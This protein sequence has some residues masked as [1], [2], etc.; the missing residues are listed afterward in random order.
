MVK[1]TVFFYLFI[2]T[3]KFTLLLL[4]ILPIVKLPIQGHQYWKFHNQ[5]MKYG[6]RNISEGF[7]NIPDN[8]DTAFVWSGNGKTY[9]VKG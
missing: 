6:P 9:F 2:S 8:I 5:N 7:D 1:S 4:D 3:I